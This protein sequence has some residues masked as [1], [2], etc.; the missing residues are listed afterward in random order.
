MD[1][2]IPAWRWKACATGQLVPV[3]RDAVLPPVL[4]RQIQV[5]EGGGA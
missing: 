5:A 3:A 1:W 4:F 2:R